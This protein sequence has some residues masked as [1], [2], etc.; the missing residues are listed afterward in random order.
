MK[1]S[2]GNQ[3]SASLF[4]CVVAEN[5]ATLLIITKMCQYFLKWKWITS[6]M[7]HFRIEFVFF[8]NDKSLSVMLGTFR[9]WNSANLLKHLDNRFQC[10][11][12]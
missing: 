5:I 11:F 9:D 3:H 10:S 4:H 1:P 2:T 8:E 12:F 6:A 7:S